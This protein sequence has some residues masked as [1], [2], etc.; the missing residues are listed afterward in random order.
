MRPEAVVVK[1]SDTVEGIVTTAMRVAG[2]IVEVVEFAKD[3]NGGCG[4]EGLRVDRA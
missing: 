1:A 2:S 3:G 4:A